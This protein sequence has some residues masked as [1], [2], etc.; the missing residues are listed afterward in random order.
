M[1]EK[2]LIKQVKP[3]G[4][5]GHIIMPVSSVS[6]EF[7]VLPIQYRFMLKDLLRSIEGQLQKK[8]SDILTAEEINVVRGSLQE[9]ID[10]P[11]YSVAGSQINQSLKGYYRYLEDLTDQDDL[12]N[13]VSVLSKRSSNKVIIKKLTTHILSRSL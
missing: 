9:E 8:L 13:I 5:G 7:I 12:K 6:R 1:N 4:K 3:F 10:S 2:E 11:V